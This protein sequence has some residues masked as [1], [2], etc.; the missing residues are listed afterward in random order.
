MGEL[1]RQN[2]TEL[3]NNLKGIS[4]KLVEDYSYL[5]KMMQTVIDKRD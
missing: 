4:E 5:Q 2:I 3:G 1:T